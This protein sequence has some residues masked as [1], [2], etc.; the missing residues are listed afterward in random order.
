MEKAVTGCLETRK[1]SLRYC[2]AIATRRIDGSHG[3][4]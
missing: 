2:V 3:L 4:D 1:F